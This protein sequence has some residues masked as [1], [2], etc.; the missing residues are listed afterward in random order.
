MRGWAA[1]TEASRRGRQKLRP[2][3]EPA[4]GDGD[5][6]GGAERG[7]RTQERDEAQDE[8]RAPA[9]GEGPL[10]ANARLHE[11][12]VHD[13]IRKTQAEVRNAG[14]CGVAKL[15]AGTASVA[16]AELG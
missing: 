2:S 4:V 14:S 13:E 5:R 1:P 12:T 15:K 8:G 10:E 11:D 16:P 3:W 9:V 7:L 6:A